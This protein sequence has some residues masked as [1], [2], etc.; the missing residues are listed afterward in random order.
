MRAVFLW[1]T[2]AAMGIGD[3]PRRH[4]Q[5]RVLTQSFNQHD[6]IEIEANGA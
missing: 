4:A 6:T 5:A 1:S 2:A 3:R